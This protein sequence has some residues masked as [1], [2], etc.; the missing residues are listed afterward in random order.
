VVVPL[1]AGAAPVEV[2][3][4]PLFDRCY[5]SGRYAARA[6]YAEQRPEPPL[7]PEQQA[8]A[9]GVLRAREFLR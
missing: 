5:D 2:D 6:R 4:Q 9:E 8:W 7:T 3:L 1:D